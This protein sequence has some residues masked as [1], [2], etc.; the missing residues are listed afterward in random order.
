[1]IRLDPE[2]LD[3][4]RAFAEAQGLL[5][6]EPSRLVDGAAVIGWHDQTLDPEWPAFAVVRP[7]GAYADLVGQILKVSTDEASCFVY[8]H[9]SAAAAADLS[10]CRRAFHELTD[11]WNETLTCIVEAI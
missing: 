1:M 3:A 9:R 5:A 10:L 6:G 2:V 7:A 8:V 11:A 4:R